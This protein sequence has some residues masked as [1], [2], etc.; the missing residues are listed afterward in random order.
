MQRI[1][2][3]GL[4]AYPAEGC[5][6]IGC[7]P[8][9]RNAV[10]TL[11]RL[12]KRH[13]DQG[14]ILVAAG[15]WQI[16]NWISPTCRGVRL[17]PARHTWPGPVTWL[18]PAAY[19]TPYWLRGHNECVALRITAHPPLVALCR[20]AGTALVSTSANLHNQVA[21]R[22]AHQV[23]AQFGNSLGRVVAGKPGGLQQCTEIR[24]LLTGRVLRAA[25]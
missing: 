1:R 11:L 2:Q 8:R 3:G 10:R 25:R 14:L 9:N 5:Y 17:D 15:E 20:A 23:Y 4:V 16:R 19:W 18:V 24:D 22:T 13:P 7:D 6:G 21:A 12:K